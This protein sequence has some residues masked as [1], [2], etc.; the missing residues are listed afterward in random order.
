[1]RRV[2]ILSEKK[3]SLSEKEWDNFIATSKAKPKT[4]KRYETERKRYLTLQK[5]GVK[6]VK[7]QFNFK[8]KRVIQK[9]GYFGRS[10][11]FATANYKLKITKANYNAFVPV[12]KQIFYASMHYKLKAKFAG[13]KVRYNVVISNKKSD[14]DEYI[15]STIQYTEEFKYAVDNLLYKIRHIVYSASVNGIIICREITKFYSGVRN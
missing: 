1:M 9:E 10:V 2:W 5:T 7:K 14:I 13:F 4:K 15:G 8:T 11:W 12:L 3:L 6:Y